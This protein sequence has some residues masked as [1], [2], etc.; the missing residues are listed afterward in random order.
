MK[1]LLKSVIEPLVRFPEEL[2]IEEKI[3]GREIVLTVSANPDDIGRVI[4]RGGRRAHAVRTIMKAK[5]AMD[6]KRVSVD[7]LS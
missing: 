1:E 3:Q 4:G 7:I 2:V 5:G 6:N